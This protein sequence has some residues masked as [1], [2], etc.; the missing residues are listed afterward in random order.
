MTPD[1]PPGVPPIVAVMA[2]CVLLCMLAFGVIVAS[3]ASQRFQRMQDRRWVRRDVTRFEWMRIGVGVWWRS[4]V[5][6]TR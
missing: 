4:V 6:R 1:E 5:R 2:V 3:I